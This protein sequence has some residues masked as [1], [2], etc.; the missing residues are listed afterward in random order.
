[1]PIMAAISKST[2]YLGLIVTASLTS[3]ADNN[4]VRIGDFD[5]FDGVGLANFDQ[6]VVEAGV[7][8]LCE[9]AG[10]SC[11]QDGLNRLNPDSNLILEKAMGDP[12]GVKDDQGKDSTLDQ[13][14]A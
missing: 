14:G 11:I 13:N 5:M 10:D 12:V 3:L 2:L 1:M 8:V 7:V 9:K 4:A 6:D